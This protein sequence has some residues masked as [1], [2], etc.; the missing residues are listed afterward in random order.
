[1]YFFP[2]VR[3]EWTAYRCP[4]GHPVAR[5]LKDVVRLGDACVRCPK[6]GLETRVDAYREWADLTPGQRRT[7]VTGDV[8]TVVFA[9]SA[10]GVVL[11]A[12]VSVMGLLAG[13]PDDTVIV[14]GAL[15]YAAG[16]GVLALRGVAAVRASQKRSAARQGPPTV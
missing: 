13:L 16:L 15:A 11:G 5:E 4:N 6:C 14:L 7:V 1:M 9:G 3:R 8:L 10:L 12:V 2:Y